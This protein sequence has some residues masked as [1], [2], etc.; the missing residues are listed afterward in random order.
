[1]IPAN[2]EVA[3]ALRNPRVAAAFEARM[4]VQRALVAGDSAAFAAGFTPDAVVNSPFNT[5]ATAA[6]AARRSRAGTLN[7]RYVHSSIEYAAARHKNEVVFMGEETYE[8]APGALHAGKTVRR[9]FTDLYR[10]HK[11]KW[12]LSLRQATIVSVQ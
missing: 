6:E 2:A 1:M 4:R 8:P 11:G 7:Y 3:A 10:R 12:L 9:R 5:V